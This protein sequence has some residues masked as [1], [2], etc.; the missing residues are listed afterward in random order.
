MRTTAM[1]F[2]AAIAAIAMTACAVMMDEGDQAS[3]NEY[4]TSEQALSGDDPVTEAAKDCSVSI[5]C[6][7]GTYR[8][9]NGTSGSCS[10][11]GSGNGSVTCNGSTS[12]CP[13]TQPPSECSTCPPGYSCFCGI[14]DGCRREGTYCP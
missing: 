14:A 9:C 4:D 10:A 6:A 11:S 3:F 1:I 13:T 5:Q 2:L 8:S 12:A 7:N